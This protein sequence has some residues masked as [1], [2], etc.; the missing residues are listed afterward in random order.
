MRIVTVMVANIWYLVS[1]SYLHMNG[2]RIHIPFQRELTLPVSSLLSR[3]NHTCI[4][5]VSLARSRPLVDLAV[6]LLRSRFHLPKH[7]MVR[8]LLFLAHYSE[9]ETL[10][11]K[12]PV[13]QT[14]LWRTVDSSV[15]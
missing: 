12:T 3:G 5:R 8:W 10:L 13:P 7:D 2:I 15:N 9:L 1:I 11:V 4:R 6:R 14:L